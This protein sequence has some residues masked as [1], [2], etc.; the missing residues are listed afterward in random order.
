M[1]GSWLGSPAQPLAPHP[2]RS[3]LRIGGQLGTVQPCD[4]GKNRPM[5]SGPAE[6]SG[7]LLPFLLCARVLCAGGSRC[8]AAL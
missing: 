8:N 7:G 6:P 3:V 1:L 4:L 2:L 5:L